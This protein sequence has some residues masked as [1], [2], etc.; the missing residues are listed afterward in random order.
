LLEYLD[1]NPDPDVLVTGSALWSIAKPD[2][3]M[4]MEEYERGLKKLSLVT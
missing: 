2:Q 3:A 1:T 4:A